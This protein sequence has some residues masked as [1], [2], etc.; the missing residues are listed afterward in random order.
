MYYIDNASSVADMPPLHARLFDQPRWFT[1][2][3]EGIEP[4]YPGA[5]WFNIIQAEM[6]NVLKLAGLSP[7][8]T[9]LDQFAQ[10]IRLMST[11]YMMPVGIP[12]P[13]PGSSAPDGF[14]LMVGQA[15]DGAAYPKL[16]VAYP[17]LVIPDMR[18]QTIKALPGAGRALLSYE[19]DGNRAHDHGLEIDGTDLGTRQT[20]SNGAYQLKMRSYRSNTSLDG[21]ESSRHTIDQDRGFT[22]FGLVEAIPDHVHELAIGWHGH[23]GRVLASG[24][25]ETTVKNIAFNYIVRLA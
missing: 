25:A 21:G 18:G 12:F 2:G 8:K 4:T 5:D 24:N 23:V 20:T 10:A 17:G 11:D 22:D 16:A 19:G 7:D 3:G 14:G 9:Q 1:E 13:W 6:V 15:F